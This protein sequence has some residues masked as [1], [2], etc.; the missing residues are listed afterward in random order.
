MGGGGMDGALELQYQSTSCPTSA[1]YWM[2]M[3]RGVRAFQ[4]TKNE[5]QIQ[6][7]S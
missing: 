1:I 3:C 7:V 6:K 2:S 5:K 4:R